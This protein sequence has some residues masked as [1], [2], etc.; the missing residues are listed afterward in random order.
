MTKLNHVFE[1]I[2][3]KLELISNGKLELEYR[4]TYYYLLIISSVL[5]CDFNN[6]LELLD[7]S[8][9]SIQTT[10]FH[11]QLKADVLYCLRD[12]D[13]ALELYAEVAAVYPNAP[14]L[15]LQMARILIGRE[16]Y[17]PQHENLSMPENC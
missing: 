1:S 4:D 13:E 10:V 3:T 7:N 15:F 6:A 14:F 9:Q 11:K 5:G 8:E 17:E 12:E 16:K 2:S